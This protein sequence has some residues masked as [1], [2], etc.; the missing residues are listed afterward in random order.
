M[1]LTGAATLPR[2]GT[3]GW[4]ATIADEYTFD[5]VRLVTQAIAD[6]AKANWRH[7]RGIV[8]GFDTRFGSDRFAKTVCEVLAANGIRSLISCDPIPTPACA[9]SVSQE[10]AAGGI[11]VTA[12]HNPPSDNGIKV[13][14]NT[15]AAVPPGELEKIEAAIEGRAGSEVASMPYSEARVVGLVKEFDPKPGYLKG[16]RS[17]VD[18]DR[19]SEA[20]YPI[21]IDSMWGSGAGYA[22]E[23]L[24]KSELDIRA[25]RDDRN[26]A[27]PGISRPEPIPP[28][29][30]ALSDMVLEV[31]AQVGFANDGDAD[32]LGV[33]DEKGRFVDQL[34]TMSLLAYYMIEH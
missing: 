33:V 27:F 20:A 23:L 5:N 30:R 15:G 32:R 4:R 1:G 17:A 10:S 21:V 9:Y 8:V 12:S 24:E 7:E 19:L 22:T 29:T 16:L 14:D 3:D 6:F 26:P 11:I 13:R 34:R 2:F 31:G 28:H 18:V 25:I